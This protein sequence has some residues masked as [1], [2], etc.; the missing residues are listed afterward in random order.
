MTMQFTA[1]VLLCRY[2]EI[3]KIWWH[4]S[5]SKI[6]ICYQTGNSWIFEFN[7]SKY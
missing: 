4:L 1:F 6:R 7:F 3:K 2:K 5:P